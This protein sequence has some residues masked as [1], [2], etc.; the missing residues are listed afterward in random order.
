MHVAII[1]DGNGR[2]ATRRG[3][4]RTAGHREG[5]KAVRRIVEYARR[6]RVD[7]LTLYAFSADNWG[8]PKTEVDALL[9]LLQR[10]L[11]SERPRCI[12]Q[13]IRVNVIGRLEGAADP[14]ADGVVA[15]Y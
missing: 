2:W 12:E 7:V 8:R 3:R 13:S 11:V 10:H 14:R 6:R 15:A 4:A 9:R 5:A 1:M